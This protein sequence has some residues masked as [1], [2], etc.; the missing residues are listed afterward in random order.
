MKVEL[1]NLVSAVESGSLN[2]LFGIGFPAKVSY[3]IYKLMDE[4]NRENKTFKESRKHVIDKFGDD[5][6]NNE[7]AQKEII[8]LGNI[9]VDISLEK[10][11]SI[12]ADTQ[13]MR[14]YDFMHLDSFIEIGE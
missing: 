11:I 7:E 13:G 5:W 8:E 3:Q 4:A 10:K 14:A 6:K 9:E 2:R 12:P 1:K